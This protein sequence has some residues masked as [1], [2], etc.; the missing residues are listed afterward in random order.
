MIELTDAV[1]K[2]NIG[3]LNEITAIDNINLRIE[4]GEMLAITGRSGAGKSTLLH[5]IGCLDGLT[6]GSCKID[7][8]ETRN[9]SDSRLAKLR[10]EKIG[11]LLQNFGLIGSETAYQNVITPLLFSKVPLR[12]MYGKAKKVLELAGVSDII[13]QKTSTMSGG[14]KQR[15]ALA[16]ALVNNPSVLLC[17]EPTGALDSKTADEI[18]EQLL[19]LNK[20]GVTI[21]IVTHDAKV[22]DCCQR[23]IQLN[24]G[25][26]VENDGVC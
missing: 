8:V 21:V 20:N 18:M 1:K 10:N 9:L 17:D 7:G 4:D 22:A 6:C 3:R 15:V 24:D 19:S 23:Q 25:R 16:R 2:F 11:I 26:I 13:G 12:K 14:Q 5:I